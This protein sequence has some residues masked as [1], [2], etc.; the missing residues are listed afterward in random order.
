MAYVGEQS[1]IV[2]EVVMDAHV[3]CAEHIK[4]LKHSEMGLEGDVW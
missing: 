4:L 1:H 3:V 2:F